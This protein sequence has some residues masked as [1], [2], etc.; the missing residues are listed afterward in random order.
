M[1]IDPV[2]LEPA[3]P[4]LVPFRFGPVDL[5]TEDD[6][7]E[8]RLGGAKG[9]PLTEHLA[10]GTIAGESEVEWQRG[11]AASGDASHHPE[12]LSPP[13]NFHSGHRGSV[14]VDFPDD[15]G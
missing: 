15:F 6:E 13:G 11:G 12:P 5:A 8:P 4:S 10:D 14:D 9:S 7:R 2:E 1:P 3:L